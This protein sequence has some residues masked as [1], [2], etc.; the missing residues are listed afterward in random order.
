ML[1]GAAAYLDCRLHAKHEAG[2]HE[3]FI[4][5]VLELGLDAEGEPLLFHGGQ[6]KLIGGT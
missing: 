2:D 6:Y 1:E 4:G 3:I 5:E